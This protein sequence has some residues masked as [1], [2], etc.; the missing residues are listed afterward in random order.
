MGQEV[1]KTLRNF[2]STKTFVLNSFFSTLSVTLEW[3]K[4]NEN[5]S[6]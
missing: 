3:L 1:S 6:C 4:V 5:G 2:V